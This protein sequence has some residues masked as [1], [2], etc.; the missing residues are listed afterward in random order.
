MPSLLPRSPSSRPPHTPADS[1][2]GGGQS[3]IGSQCSQP[4]PAFDLV[5][6]VKTASQTQLQERTVPSDD[7][8]RL[9]GLWATV[10]RAQSHHFISY[11]CLLWAWAAWAHLSPARLSLP[12][13]WA[14]TSRP[15]LTPPVAV[16]SKGLPLSAC[17]GQRPGTHAYLETSLTTQQ[18]EV[19]TAESMV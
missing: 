3:I 4:N 15:V 13:A 1:M 19:R 11:P 2:Q 8:Y 14:Q 16:G 6:N 9:L 18:Q 10:L 17:L 5:S 7:S 12:P